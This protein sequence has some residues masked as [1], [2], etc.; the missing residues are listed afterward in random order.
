VPVD[1]AGSG[2]DVRLA[3][4][5]SEGKI[6]SPAGSVGAGGAQADRIRT[7]IKSRDDQKGRWLRFIIYSLSGGDLR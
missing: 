5:V 7:A 3:V 2:L 6:S 4:G 1:V